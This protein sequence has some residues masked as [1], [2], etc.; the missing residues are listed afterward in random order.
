[1]VAKQEPPRIYYLYVL[2]IFASMAGAILLRQPL[3]LC[4]G[5]VFYNLLRRDMRKRQQEREKEDM[6]PK[7]ERNKYGWEL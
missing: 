4:L 5:T 2:G 6:E 3:V 1:M 7:W